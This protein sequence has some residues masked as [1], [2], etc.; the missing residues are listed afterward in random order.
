MEQI[1][2][3]LGAEF[4]KVVAYESL[5]DESQCARCGYFDIS[6]PDVQRILR[7]RGEFTLTQA[8]CKCRLAE[9]EA[10]HKRQMRWQQS[11]VLQNGRSFD[12]FRVTPDL[13]EMFQTCQAFAQGEGA[14]ILT[15]VGPTGVGK[16][17][18]LEAAVRESVER[19]HK[20]RYE[21]VSKMLD[22]FRSTYTDDSEEDLYGLMGWYQ[23]HFLLALDDIGLEKGTE[24]AQE[25]LT[26]MVEDRIHL[27][28]RTI[29]STNKT[30][31][32]MAER[33]GD[34]MASRL[35]ATNPDLHDTRVLI[36]DAPDYRNRRRA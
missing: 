30:R 32:E 28:W 8:R 12:T 16:S 21:L 22:R 25:K 20:A 26:A 11:N 13:E 17:H 34:R 33:L 35:Y 19:G 3:H 2:T 18:M 5:P 6:H 10:E 23:G 29:V 14:P 31:D 24:F 27:G 7:R 4:G 1:S 36:V 9:E 15:L